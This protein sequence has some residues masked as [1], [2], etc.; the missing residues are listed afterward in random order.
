MTLV[1]KRTAS[2]GLLTLSVM[3]IGACGSGGSGSGAA[4]RES[5]NGNGSP[6][7]ALKEPVK[8]TIYYPWSGYPKETFMETYGNYMVQK[9]PNISIEYIQS[10]RGT[11]M[12]E[13]IASKAELDLIM[14]TSNAYQSLQDR[15]LNGDITE[16]AKKYQYDFNKLDE[17]VYELTKA[18]EPGKIAGLPLKVNAPGFFYNKDLFDKFG[19]PYVKDGVTWDDVYETAKKLTREDGGI[20]YRG[21]GIRS[22][23]FITFNQL[24]LPRLDA[25]SKAVFNNGEWKSFLDN[26]IR[27][28][29]LPGFAP[30]KDA[31]GIAGAATNMF[32]KDRTLAMLVQMNSDW[33]KAEQGV[34]MNWDAATFPEF[35]SHPGVGP[36]PEAVYFVVPNTS[37]KRDAAFLAMAAL[38]DEELQ[39]KAAKSGAAPVL[40][41][42][43]WR[44]VYGSEEPN[45]KGKNAVALV[46]KKYAPTNG[47]NQYNVIAETNIAATV[48]GVILGATDMNSALRV[49]EEATNKAIEEKLR[50]K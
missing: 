29:Q 28:F 14:T 32:L 36:Q 37:K 33:P 12:D 46:P 18:L 35:K 30:T 25:T 17:T 21:F 11:T 7:A 20:Q 34:Q 3:L 26:F 44:D 40:K 42:A 2:L 13:L 24:S 15:G 27:F 10:G 23:N 50:A 38:T 16:L 4:N 22:T 1:I 8:L 19:V 43:K 9:Y 41:S 45:L 49:A 48:N 31:T 6:A 39:F 47:I 5:T